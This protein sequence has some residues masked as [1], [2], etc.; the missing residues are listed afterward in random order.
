MVVV[1]V[2]CTAA[3]EAL[4]ADI[5]AQGVVLPKLDIFL[6]AC[7]IFMTNKNVQ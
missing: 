3:V 5:K 4:Q 6:R 1:A 7:Q 2:A